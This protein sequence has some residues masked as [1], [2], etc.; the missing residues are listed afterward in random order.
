MNTIKGKLEA[1]ILTQRILEVSPNGNDIVLEA[2][3]GASATSQF[4][5]KRSKVDPDPLKPL[6]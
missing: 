2:S 5:I 3:S 1:T 4:F 6:L